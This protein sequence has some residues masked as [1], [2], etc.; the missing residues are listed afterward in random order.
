MVTDLSQTALFWLVIGAMT[1]VNYAIRVSG[2]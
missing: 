1:A 2:T